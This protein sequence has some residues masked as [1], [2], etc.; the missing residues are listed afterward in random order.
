[1]KKMLSITFL[2]LCS[3]VL[4]CSTPIGF[5]DAI[6]NSLLVTGWSLDA[7]APLTNLTIHFYAN[8]P[9]GS[10]GSVFIGSTLANYPRPDVNS[11]T[12][13]SGNHGFRWRIPTNLITPC[14]L[15]IYAYGIDPHGVNNKLLNNSPIETPYLEGQISASAGGY[16]IVLKANSKFAGG[17]YSLTWNGVEFIDAADHGRELQTASSFY[18]SYSPPSWTAECYNP[19]EAGNHGDGSGGCTSS[20]LLSFSTAGYI[21]QTTTQ[22]A[23]YSNSSAPTGSCPSPINGYTILSNHIMSKTVTIGIPGMAHAIKYE[24]SHSVPSD[25]ANLAMGQFE[26][27]TGY[28]P[29]SFNTFWRFNQGNST[30]TN[31]T[32]EPDNEAGR[33]I[34]L[35][36]SSG[37]YAM[38]VYCPAIGQAATNGYGQFSFGSTN[39]WNL[40]QRI[41]NIFAGQTYNFTAYICVGSLENVRVTMAQLVANYPN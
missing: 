38:G 2:L 16:P 4:F 11:A 17:I 29:S 10:P 30:L 33:P 19:T 5:L 3:K 28:M 25:E 26:V 1:M 15:A 27:V 24:V 13:Y 23:F 7:A 31:V 39:K 36:K 6:D 12:G 41:P 9:A 22:M 14:R 35:A 8:A 32:N 18:S 37:D 34:I 20:E 21:L 40:V